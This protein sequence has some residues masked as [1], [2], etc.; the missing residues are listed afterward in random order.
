M[1]ILIGFLPYV[2]YTI[3]VIYFKKNGGQ[4]PKKLILNLAANC[5]GS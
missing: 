4:I 1:R 5:L 2:T 3:F